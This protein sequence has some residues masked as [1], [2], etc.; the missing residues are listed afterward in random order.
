MHKRLRLEA[1]LYTLR[2]NSL[3][4]S[5]LLGGINFYMAAELPGKDD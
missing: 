3:G 2:K 1:S 5:M 4:R